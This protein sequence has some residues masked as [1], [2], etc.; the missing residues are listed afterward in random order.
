M[1]QSPIDCVFVSLSPWV[2]QKKI[3]VFLLLLIS[4][5][6]MFIL[7]IYLLIF[8]QHYEY[9][10]FYFS[11][12]LTR[13][14]GAHWKIKRRQRRRRQTERADVQIFFSILFFKQ[15]Y[16]SSIKFRTPSFQRFFVSF[17]VRTERKVLQR[18][19]L[20][21]FFYLFCARA[22]CVGMTFSEAVLFF[23]THCVIDDLNMISIKEKRIFLFLFW[24]IVTVEKL[25]EEKKNVA[26]FWFRF[27][28]L[29]L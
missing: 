11:H 28:S 5:C 16:F 10:S 22:R 24:S 12:R 6:F 27:I 19:S 3:H 14:H 15:N 29:H 20:L 23:S 26:F 2:L 13:E 17:L 8:L 25:D 18:I 4:L 7:I 9:S 1:T 21:D